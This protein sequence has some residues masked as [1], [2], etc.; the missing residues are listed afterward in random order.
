MLEAQLLGSSIESQRTPTA[1]SVMKNAN[2][3]NN[4]SLVPNL[5]LSKFSDPPQVA[6]NVSQLSPAIVLDRKN[7]RL[8]ADEVR[9]S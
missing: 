9:V 3:N 7:L 6:T 8:D 2:I 4:S 5:E 1:A